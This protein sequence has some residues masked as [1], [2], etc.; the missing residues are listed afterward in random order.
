MTTVRIGRDRFRVVPFESLAPDPRHAASPAEF[1]AELRRLKAWSDLTYR[2]LEKEAMR[3]GH[4]LPHSTIA[5]A[6]KRESLP[7]TELVAALVSAC[8]CD[9]AA[10]ALWVAARQRLSTGA[11]APTGS[12]PAGSSP[13]APH[14]AGTAREDRPHGIAPARSPGE[15]GTPAVPVRP[16]GTGPART[17]PGRARRIGRTASL[18]AAL[19]AGL[20]VIGASSAPEQDRPRAGHPT[21]PAYTSLPLPLPAAWWRFEEAGGATAY[22]SSRHGADATIGGGVTR[23]TV[24]GG[25]ALTFD[26]GG[27]ATARGPVVRTDEAFT[28]TAWVRL[29]E[30]DDWGT[31]VSEHH[32]AHAPDVAL[33]D[34]DA[35]H[36]DWAFMMP[37]RRK[38]WAMGKE[39]VFAGL[40][41]APARWTHL[42]VVHD[43]ADR[44]VC[45]YVD[46]SL[47]ACRTRDSLTRANGP[48]DIGRAI[49]DGEPVDGWHGAIDDVRV[50]PAALDRAQVGEVAGHRA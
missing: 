28:I 33:L 34:Y 23:T 8:G 48:L 3:R 10:V 45:L 35:E 29:D 47:E 44:R 30:T 36:R 42:A 6:L 5:T 13:A 27:H 39:T 2:Q 22:D 32:G 40:R 11:A 37:E 19:L 25:H 49:H 9:D 31:V 46:G 17:R 43:P 7:R 14:D 16:R 15:A 18:A 12:S 4:V 41:P 1:V 21:P 24:P 38:G 26:G 50:F 20:V